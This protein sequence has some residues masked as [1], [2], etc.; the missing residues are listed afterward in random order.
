ACQTTDGDTTRVRTGTSLFAPSL[1]FVDPPGTNLLP[2]VYTNAF[3]SNCVEMPN[4]LPS[5]PTVFYNLHDGEPI[6][7]AINRTSPTTDLERILDRAD[8]VAADGQ[9]GAV[10]PD[11]ARA[12]V[13]G[14]AF[15]VDILEGNPVPNRA[16]SGFPLLHYT[17]PLKY[18]R[19]DPTYD[20]S[21]NV[22]GGNVDVHQI[23]YDNHI[24]S[25]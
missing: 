11:A 12:A 13:A 17:G 6:A 1:P 14:L 3:D 18:K 8:A 10:D 7:T 23:W 5:T 4:T 24:E 20:A 19:V 15:A 16:Y 25:D 21:G 2:N 9:R 22:I